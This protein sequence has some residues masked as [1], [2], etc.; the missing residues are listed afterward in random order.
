M[1][2]EEIICLMIGSVRKEEHHNQN[3]QSNTNH[4]SYNGESS[5]YFNESLSV[6]NLTVNSNYNN[7]FYKKTDSAEDVEVSWD[8]IAVVTK[9]I[10]PSLCVLGLMGNILNLTVI[11]KRVSHSCDIIHVTFYKYEKVNMVVIGM[12]RVCRFS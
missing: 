8:T 7:S 10:I 11:M 1:T 4:D 6:L 2:N 9:I 12:L 5:S 3:K